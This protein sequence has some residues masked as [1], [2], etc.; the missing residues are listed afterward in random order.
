MVYFLKSA[1]RDRWRFASDVR[2][3]E[4]TLR[5]GVLRVASAEIQTTTWLPIDPLTLSATVL[6]VSDWIDTSRDGLTSGLVAPGYTIV[7]LRGDYAISDQVKLFARVGNLF[8]QRYQNPTG[9]LAPG[10]GIFGGLR[11][12]SYGV[13]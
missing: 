11:F 6:H 13:Q 8:N 12:A 9:F 1:R 7:N 2:R 4:S 3:A 5:L 10:L